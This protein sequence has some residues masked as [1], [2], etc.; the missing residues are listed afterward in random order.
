MK[1][2]M[3]AAI[4]QNMTEHFEYFNSLCRDNRDLRMYNRYDVMEF[5]SFNDPS[6]FCDNDNVVYINNSTLENN[7]LTTVTTFSANADDAMPPFQSTNF[8]LL[9]RVEGDE[10]NPKSQNIYLCQGYSYG[11]S[12]TVFVLD[13]NMFTLKELKYWEILPNFYN[14]GVWTDDIYYLMQYMALS[15]VTIDEYMEWGDSSGDIWFEFIVRLLAEHPDFMNTS[16]IFYS[17]EM[18][19]AIAKEVRKLKLNQALTK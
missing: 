16:H 6:I 4:P 11:Y 12:S 7:K 14:N 2:K 19:K 8:E 1:K 18:G 17:P 5:E 13:M 10:Q 9:V 3:I 15:G